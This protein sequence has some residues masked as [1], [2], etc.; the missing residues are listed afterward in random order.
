MPLGPSDPLLI[1]TLVL[2]PVPLVHEYWVA[3]P[4]ILHGALHPTTYIRA[5]ISGLQ[6]VLDADGILVATCIWVVKL[7]ALNTLPTPATVGGMMLARILRPAL[8]PS[9]RPLAR[10]ASTLLL[11]ATI[12]L[13]VV[14]I[15]GVLAS[16][17]A[18]APE[19]S[20]PAVQP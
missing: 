12:L 20:L 6:R 17:K 5:R 14:L 10:A 1:A 15:V 19:A 8:P 7:V 2:G 11:F 4:Q 9:L 3:F 18:L 16:F 13:N